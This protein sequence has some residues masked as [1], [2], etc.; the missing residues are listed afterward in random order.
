MK[1]KS[2]TSCVEGEGLSRFTQEPIFS[3]TD[4]TKENEYRVFYIEQHVLIHTDLQFPYFIFVW[5]LT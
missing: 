2:S 4:L 1:R 5:N 3:K